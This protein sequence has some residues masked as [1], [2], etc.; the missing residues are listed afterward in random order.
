[1]NQLDLLA[2]R[3][4]ARV[5]N[6]PIDMIRR[7]PTLIRACHLAMEVAGLEDKEIY[8]ELDLDAGAFSRIRKGTAWLPQDERFVRFLDLIQNDIPLIWLAEKRGFDWSTIRPHRSDLERE[9]ERLRQEIADRDR[10]LSLILSHAS[11]QR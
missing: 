5:E 10:S 2:R 6:V 8:G 9:N 7:R 1:M 3:K 4:K 11:S